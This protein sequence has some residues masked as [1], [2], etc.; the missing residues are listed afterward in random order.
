MPGEQYKKNAEE[1][2]QLARHMI[3]PED[4]AKLEKMAQ[5]WEQLA[6]ERTRSRDETS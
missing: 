2:R 6:E 4:R 5:A 3:R 1:C